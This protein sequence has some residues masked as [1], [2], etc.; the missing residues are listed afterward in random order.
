MVLGQT[1]WTD[2]GVSPHG[3]NWKEFVYMVD[4][5]GMP[6]M[7]AIQSATMG[8]AML[9]GIEDELGSLEVGK[10]ADVVAVGGDPLSDIS[11]MGDVTLVMKEGVIYKRPE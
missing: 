4:D 9:L 11:T 5:G 1:H 7:E 10:I 6:A 8:G 3:D 2:S